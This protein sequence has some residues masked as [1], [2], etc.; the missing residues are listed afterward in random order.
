MW[1]GDAATPRVT[2]ETPTPRDQHSPPRKFQRSDCDPDVVDDKGGSSPLGPE[3]TCGTQSSSKTGAS[4]T[5]VDDEVRGLEM[6]GVEG[7]NSD[8]NK[9]FQDSPQPRG[10]RPSCYSYLHFDMP[11]IDSL[12]MVTMVG[13]LHCVAV[14]SDATVQLYTINPE[15]Q[16]WTVMTSFVIEPNGTVLEAFAPTVNLQQDGATVLLPLSL[17][18]PSSVDGHSLTVVEMVQRGA[19]AEFRSIC[20][21][22]EVPLVSDGRWT[23]YHQVGHAQLIARRDADGTCIHLRGYGEA[24]LGR[25]AATIINDC[26]W[27]VNCDFACVERFSLLEEWARERPDSAESLPVE[28]ICRAG[29]DDGIVKARFEVTVDNRPFLVIQYQDWITLYKMQECADPSQTPLVPIWVFDLSFPDEFEPRYISDFTLMID[30]GQMFFLDQSLNP[31]RTAVLMATQIDMSSTGSTPIYASR[32]D[33]WVAAEGGPAN[34]L[35]HMD[36]MRYDHT[37]QTLLLARKHSCLWITMQLESVPD[38]EVTQPIKLN[39]SGDSHRSLTIE[40]MRNNTNWRREL[41]IKARRQLTSTHPDEHVFPVVESVKQLVPGLITGKALERYWPDWVAQPWGDPWVLLYG[42]GV[43]VSM[44][45]VAVYI[46]AYMNYAVIRADFPDGARYFRLDRSQEADH[47]Q[48]SMA[49]RFWNQHSWQGCLDESAPGNTDGSSWVL[50]FDA[51]C[52]E[53]AA[54]VERKKI[55]DELNSGP[56]E[57]APS[58]EVLDAWLRLGFISVGDLSNGAGE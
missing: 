21:S 5:A 46:T 23:V 33:A 9:F 41:A 32:N 51:L 36:Y 31:N 2:W 40:A 24:R 57:S 11:I 1:D 26:L 27:V 47:I 13:K 18:K 10:L 45:L 22:T 38:R 15:T 30:S 3:S 37:K 6:A 12:A 20:P 8:A 35:K 48:G 50:H 54:Q 16:L 53:E 19:T 4:E 56:D 39:I 28:P 34:L 25:L 29:V 42:A 7:T 49:L 58:P 52:T 43:D 14:T 55:A 44:E 17:V